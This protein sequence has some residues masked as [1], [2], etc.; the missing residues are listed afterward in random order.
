MHRVDEYCNEIVNLLGGG[1]TV[2]IEVNVTKF[3]FK[4]NFVSVPIGKFVTRARLWEVELNAFV[5]L[6]REGHY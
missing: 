4:E 1:Y 5:K 2:V 3:G 6:Y